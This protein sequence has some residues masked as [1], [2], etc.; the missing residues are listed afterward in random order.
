MH[1]MFTCQE[2]DFL[3][4]GLSMTFYEFLV[5]I[6]ETSQNSF[7]CV[8]LWF[9]IAA[10]RPQDYYFFNVCLNQLAQLKWEQI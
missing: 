4:P 8:S 10:I 1:L 2:A 5:S 6:N 3:Y 9:P 7:L